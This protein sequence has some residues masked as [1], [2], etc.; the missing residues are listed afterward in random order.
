MANKGT[1]CLLTREELGRALR[2]MASEIL[3]GCG[4]DPGLALVGIRTRGEPL[5]RRLAALLG[6]MEGLAPPVGTLDIGIHRDD[7]GHPVEGPAAGP[8]RVELDVGDR[9]LV[10]VDDVFFTGRTVRAALDA[11]M[12]L[13]RPRRIWYAALIDRGHREL[14]FRPDFT[15]KNVPTSR[16]E[17]VSVRLAETDGEEG[18]W[19]ERAG[20][21]R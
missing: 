2:R 16:A 13:G 6:E 10:L 14:P 4:A 3:E 20:G 19:L 15:G 8:T 9:Q 5:A 17:R 1:V 7:L 21:D 12:E 11:L 18:V